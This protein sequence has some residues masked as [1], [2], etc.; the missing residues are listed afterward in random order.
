MEDALETRIATLEREMQEVRKV[1]IV[2]N[3]TPPLTSR[4]AAVEQTLK[5]QTWL[6][7]TILGAVLVGLVKQF[8]G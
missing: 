8:I 2:G 7:R 4:M 5:T 1:V 3:G 6:L